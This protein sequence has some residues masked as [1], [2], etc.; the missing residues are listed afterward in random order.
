MIRCLI[1][2]VLNTERFFLYH[3]VKICL[4]AWMFF[5]IQDSRLHLNLYGKKDVSLWEIQIEQIKN[6]RCYFFESWANENLF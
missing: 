4:A 1:L 6:F 5:K 2:G 3:S